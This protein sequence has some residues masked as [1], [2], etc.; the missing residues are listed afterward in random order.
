MTLA[1]GITSSLVLTFSTFALRYSNTSTTQT[2]FIRYRSSHWSASDNPFN[3]IFNMEREVISGPILVFGGCGFLG[4]HLV[5]EIYSN[6]TGKPEVA[7]VDLN[8]ERNR[9]P[10]ASYFA[11]DITQRKQV[12]KL[13]DHIRPQVVFHTV[14]PNPFEVDRS[15]LEK[16]NV[17]GTQNLIECAKAVGTVRAFVFTSSSSVVHDQRHPLVE[18]TEDLPALFYPEQ[19]EWYSHTKAVAEGIVLEAN[20][21]R[22]MLTASLRPASMYGPGDGGM[23]TNIINQV[24]SGRAKYRFGSGSWLFDTTY[25]ENCTHAQLLLAR[26]LVKAA[27]SAPLPKDTRVEGEAFVISNDEH[28]PFW[29]VQTLVADIAGLPVADKDVRCIPVWLV[30]TVAIFGEWIYWIFSFGKKQ[31]ML[32]SWGVQIITMERTFCIDK[33]KQRLGYEA[34]FSN[35][36]G[37]EKSLEWALQNENLSDKNK[38]V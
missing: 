11:V 27:T 24:L 9:H 19:P 3:P 32:R 38:T 18:A 6:V 35:R 2:T 22:G 1:Q 34:Q 8:I 33:A 4:R 28:I 36:E 26:K 5:N 10:S 15:L 37:W 17:V 12:A 7:I 25:V 30:M 16:V 31:P 14:S 21:E 13:F 23:T 29:D 20:R